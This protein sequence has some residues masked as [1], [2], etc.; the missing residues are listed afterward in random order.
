MDE[1]IEIFIGESNQGKPSIKING[2]NYDELPKAPVRRE[3]L[4]R[5]T[6]SINMN[7]KIK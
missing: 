2:V 3:P 5:T 1:D 7:G 4:A 6:T